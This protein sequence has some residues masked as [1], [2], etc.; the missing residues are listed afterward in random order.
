MLQ[1][2]MKQQS[3]GA[4]PKAVYEVRMN[5]ACFTPSCIL[6]GIGYHGCV[7]TYFDEDLCDACHLEL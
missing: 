1:M 2:A 3:G 4:A 5:L 6:D 7:G